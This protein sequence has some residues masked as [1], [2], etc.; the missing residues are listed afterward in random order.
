[1]HE[2][3]YL[4]QKPSWPDFHW[5]HAALLKPLGDCRFRQG[6]L[7]ARMKGLGMDIE[8]SARAEILTQEALKTSEIEGERLDIDAVRSS[9]ARRLGLPTAGLPSTRDRRADGVIDILMDA[10]LHHDRPL[11]Q[12]RLFGW[13]ACLFPTG[14]SGLH[15]IRVA[16]WRDDGTGPMRVVSG[17]IGRETIHYEAPPAQCVAG[18]MERFIQWWEAGCNGTDGL[19]RAAVGHFRFVAIHPFEDGNG[20]IARTLTEM[21]LAAD[22]N[23]STRYYSLSARIMAEREF[24]Y[25]VLEHTNKGDGDITDWI[26]WFLECMSRAIVESEKLLANIMLKA[27][28]WQYYAQTELKERQ[29]KI[30]NRLLEAGPGGF[31]GGL[32]NRKYAATCHV[33]KATAQRELADL[34]EKGLLR[35]NPGRGRSVGYDVLWEAFAGDDGC[36]PPV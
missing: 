20:R 29:R 35:L 17:P 8:L 7:L 5:D 19:I 18:E 21:A 6:A 31:E 14:Y 13:H 28:F 36:F 33:S 12:E 11:T 25:H 32:T 4:W 16:A 23:L 22:E 15:K 10:T 27:R 1:M 9:V 3:R 2:T 30:L 34:V 26:K 24:Y